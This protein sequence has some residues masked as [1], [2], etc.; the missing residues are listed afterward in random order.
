MEKKF[1][2]CQ[3]CG[4]AIYAF[5]QYAGNCLNCKQDICRECARVYNNDLFCKKCIG[6]K[7]QTKKE[8]VGFITWFANKGI[9]YIDNYEKF[10][11]ELWKRAL[12]DEE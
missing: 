5:N 10:A 7:T 3:V 2:S 9:D 1:V 11:K 4:K 12:E 8:E 6:I